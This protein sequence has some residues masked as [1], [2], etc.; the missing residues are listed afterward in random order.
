MAENEMENK[1]KDLTYIL[2]K[3][4]NSISHVKIKNQLSDSIINFFTLAIGFFMYGCIHTEIIFSNETKYLIYG[5]IIISGITQIILGI[6]EWYK[7][8]SLYILINFS[9]GL[10]FVSWFLKYNLIENNEIEKNKRYEGAFYIIWFLLSIFIIIAGKNK[11]IIYLINYAVVALGFVF[12]FI[13]KYIDKNWLK[14]TYGCIFIVSG[15]LF[16]ITGLI[17]LINSSF[18][19][20]RF[21]LVKE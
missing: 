2:N 13:D 9:F 16:W 14:Q 7:G 6:Y 21:G 4:Q 1:P 15:G 17:R 11:G 8:K 12:L 5:T 20:N 18:L 19:S 3:I 10:L